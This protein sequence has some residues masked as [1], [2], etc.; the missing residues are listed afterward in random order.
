MDYLT[1][2]DHSAPIGTNP[3]RKE[4]ALALEQLR[5]RT[6]WGI[7]RMRSLADSALDALVDLERALLDAD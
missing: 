7:L 6:A 5:E 1:D 3:D 4:P 2:D